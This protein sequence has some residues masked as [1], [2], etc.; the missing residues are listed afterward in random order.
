MVTE[1]KTKTLIRNTMKKKLIKLAALAACSAPAAAF[2]Q[3][4]DLSVVEDAVDTGTTLGQSVLTAVLGFFA[5]ALAV[6]FI[7]KARR[8]A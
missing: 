7:K 2:A 4:A 6:G 8:S 3:A 1:G 5:V